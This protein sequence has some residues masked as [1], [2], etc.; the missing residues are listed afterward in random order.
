MPTTP[1]E[2]ADNTLPPSLHKAGLKAFHPRHI[3]RMGWLLMRVT[4]GAIAVLLL[5]AAIAWGALLFQ[6]LPR[7]DHWRG[8]LSEQ[9]TRAL[10]VRVQIGQIVGH[11]QGAW[12]VLSLRDVR[13]LDAQGGLAVAGGHGGGLA[14]DL[15]ADGDLAA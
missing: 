14:Q 12:P 9:A 10:G 2:T 15:V 7:I 3:G 8:D 4:A 6:I 13:L 1:A 5:L 11:A